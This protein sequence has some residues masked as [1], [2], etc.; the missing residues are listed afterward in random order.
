VIVVGVDPRDQV[1][2]VDEPRYRVYFWQDG[3]S[4]EYQLTGADVHDV[5][6]WA[7]RNA[8]GRTYSLSACL[9][10]PGLEVVKLVRLAGWDPPADETRRPSHAVTVP[11]TGRP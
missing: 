4:D 8:A 10:V 11:S 1:E 3:A 6:A 9:P 7:D 2:Q 5:V